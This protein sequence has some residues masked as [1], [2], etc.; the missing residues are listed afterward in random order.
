LRTLAR[1]GSL[2]LVYAARDSQHNDATVLRDLLL[3]DQSDQ[4]D[5][6]A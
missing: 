3:G 1:H 4:R 5:Q 6:G 2:T